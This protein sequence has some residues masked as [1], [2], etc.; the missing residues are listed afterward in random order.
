MSHSLKTFCSEPFLS[1]FSTF[2]STTAAAIIFS[3]TPKQRTAQTYFYVFMVR[4]QTDDLI[5]PVWTLVRR[6]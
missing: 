5:H 1:S 6:L 3:A 2:F 4:L